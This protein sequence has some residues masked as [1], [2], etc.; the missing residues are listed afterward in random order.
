MEKIIR[1]DVNMVKYR[2]ANNGTGC[3]I[4]EFNR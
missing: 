3:V 1:N 4:D 2:Q